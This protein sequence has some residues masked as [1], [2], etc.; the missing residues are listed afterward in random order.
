MPN[1][2]A[3]A[4]ALRKAKKATEKNREM[5]A[6]IKKIRK[7][8][9]EAHAAKEAAKVTELSKKFHQMVDKAGKGSTLHRNTANRLKSRL[10]AKLKVS[11]A[12][13]A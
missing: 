3:A 8:I 12:K 5:K 1:K 11:P 6:Q 10:A 9:L 7:Q 2:H 13:A 4:K